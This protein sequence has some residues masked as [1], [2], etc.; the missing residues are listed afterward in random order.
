MGNPFD[1][2]AVV[3]I[4]GMIGIIL[5]FILYIL[6]LNGVVIDEYVSESLTIEELMA[7]AIIIWTIIGVV[8]AA[9]S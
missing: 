7:I 1:K 5:A 3:F 6:N 4:C 8:I 2:F 9:L